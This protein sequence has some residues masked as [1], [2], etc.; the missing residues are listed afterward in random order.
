MQNI[1]CKVPF[2]IGQLTNVPPMGNP[3][4]TIDVEWFRS[5]TYY[6]ISTLHW[7][8]SLFARMGLHNTTF[9]QCLLQKVKNKNVSL[10]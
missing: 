6:L 10:F 9:L 3:F 4:F 1:T 2:N 8:F 7:E 5:V